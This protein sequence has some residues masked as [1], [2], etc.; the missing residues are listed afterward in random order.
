M[1]LSLGAGL[2]FCLGSYLARLEL[3]I[4]L[5]RL[6]SEFPRM[7]IVGNPVYRDTFHFYGLRELKIKNKA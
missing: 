5:V 6:I 3:E 7:Q 2:H 4:A 1:N